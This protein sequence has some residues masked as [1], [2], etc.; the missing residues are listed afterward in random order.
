MARE[1]DHADAKWLAS[2]FPNGAP[3]V[4]EEARS[5]FFRQGSDPRAMFFGAWAGGYMEKERVRRA[6][7]QGYAPAQARMASQRDGEGMCQLA[8][9]LWDG[10]GCEKDEDKALLVWKEAAHLCDRTAQCDYG[11]RAFKVSE[12]QRDRWWGRAALQGCG[13]AVNG[14]ANKAMQ[15]LDCDGRVL[16]EIGAAFEGNVMLTSLFGFSYHKSVIEAVERVVAQ[17]S[18]WCAN[19]RRAVS[20]WI[21]IARL[22]EVNKDVRVIIANLV[23]NERAAWRNVSRMPHYV[24]ISERNIKWSVLGGGTTQLKLR[25]GQFATFCPTLTLE[26]MY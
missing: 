14:L 8:E 6:A 20:C 19:A 17:H 16:F 23:W 13:I 11:K 1:C 12:W 3:A 4:K 9:C 2:L 21:W 25:T 5:V 10:V 22:Q 26:N 15:S 18:E 7:H 24:A